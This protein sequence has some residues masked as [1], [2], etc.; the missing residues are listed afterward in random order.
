[1]YPLHGESSKLILLFSLRAGQEELALPLS[2]S[3]CELQPTSSVLD[4][5]KSVRLFFLEN[6]LEVRE[7]LK[8]GNIG[9]WA[10]PDQSVY[11]TIGEAGQ[12]RVYNH[13]DSD[14][15][16]AVSDRRTSGSGGCSQYSV[17][18]NN[19]QYWKRSADEDVH[20][21]WG[22]C[23]GA[24]SAQVFQ[25]RVGKILHIQSLPSR[26]AWEGATST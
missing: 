12:I 4:E 2:P 9:R 22:N 3:P 1:M 25:G 7:A 20:V 6:S 23:I 5:E 26:T 16:A 8:I 21:S 11:H 24:Q 15:Y 14:I 19:W 13:L 17:K 10:Y 18:R